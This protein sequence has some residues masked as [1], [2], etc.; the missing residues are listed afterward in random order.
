MSQTM[1]QQFNIQPLTLCFYFIFFNQAGVLA[2]SRLME[3]CS[4]MPVILLH[5]VPHD[6]QDARS[7][8][9][10]PLYRTR[11]RGTTFVWAFNLPSREDP[12]KW[13]LAGVALLLQA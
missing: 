7:L 3:L 2:E 4:P 6:R 11:E 10:C 5:A 9:A 12:A 13:T 1:I 8:Y